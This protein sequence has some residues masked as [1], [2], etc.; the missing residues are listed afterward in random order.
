MSGCW[1]EHYPSALRLVDSLMAELTSLQGTGACT[2][3]ILKQ[4]GAYAEAQA[5]IGHSLFKKFVGKLK[6]PDKDEM[7][8]MHSDLL[9][10]CVT[11]GKAV[12]RALVVLDDD[13]FDIRSPVGVACL[14]TGRAPSSLSADDV[15]RVE[16]S[17][18]D[19]T[20]WLE[21]IQE[22]DPSLPAPPPRPSAH[23]PVE[24]PIPL[25]HVPNIYKQLHL[26]AKW[27]IIATNAIA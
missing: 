16:S 1:E 17:I 11:V 21:L 27:K 5:K 15:N 24:P 3:E 8:A 9:R 18:Y 19:R 6:G 4:L 10:L 14:L 23:C 7:T 12:R 22:L 13:P 25:P 2:R 26:Q 20:A